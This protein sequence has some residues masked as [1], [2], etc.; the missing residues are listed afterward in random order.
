MLFEAPTMDPREMD[1]LA[2]IETLKGDLRSYLHEPKRWNGSLRRL[3]FARN[4]QGSNSIE[5]FTAALD[6]AV[7]VVLGEEPLDA[8]EET[9]LALE[10]Y[11]DA[12]TFVLQSADDEELSYSGQLLKS[13]HFMMTKHSLRYR[14]GRWRTGPVYVQREEDG[15]I[16]YEGV[17]WTSIV[18]LTNELTAKLNDP[19]DTPAI[20]RAALAH[21]NLVMIHPF[22]DGNGRMARCLQSFVLARQGVLY[23]EFMSIEE[24]L[25]RNTK[26]YYDVLAQVGQ[27]SWHPENGTR[28]WLRFVLTAHLRQARTVLSRVQESDRIWTELEGLTQRVGLPERVIPGLWDAAFGLR[29][30]NATYRATVDEFLGAEISEQTASRDLKLLIDA[31]L[32]RAHGERRGRYYV[33]TDPLRKVVLDARSGRPP[34]DDSDPFGD[35]T[36]RGHRAPRRP[37]PAPDS[38]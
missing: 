22:T 13:L 15:S 24:Y 27:G 29:I 26:D 17:E 31:Q 28:P 37:Q 33:G 30:R 32:I 34:R 14:P 10:G 9:R 4:V 18:A 21:L 38:H 19:S 8:S 3:S 5:G 20:V 16:V 36:E 23:P 12:M 25:G 2:D 7:A 1:V 11:R 6:D 35:P